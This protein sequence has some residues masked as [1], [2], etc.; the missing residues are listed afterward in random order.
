MKKSLIIIIAILLVAV[1]V[2]FAPNVKAARSRIQQPTTCSTQGTSATTLSTTSI[3]YISTAGT[4]TSTA[5]CNMRNAGEGTEVFDTAVVAIQLTASSTTSTLVGKV[6]ESMDG[7]D[8]YPILR[9]GIA[10]STAPGG[11]IS[12]L[13]DGTL[14]W[15]FASSSTNGAGV[16]GNNNFATQ[17]FEIPVHMNYVRVWFASKIGGNRLGVWANII[18]KTEQNQF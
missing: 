16:A 6:E 12:V 18:G 9:T 10:T 11:G 3:A 13:S 4:A 2:G 17:S 8:W 15:T 1:A 7:I 5:T 14:S